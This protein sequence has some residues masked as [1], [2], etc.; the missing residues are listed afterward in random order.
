LPGIVAVFTAADI[1]RLV[2]PLIAVS[3]MKDYRPTPMHL[4]AS[5]KVR[6]VG[7][8]TVAVLAEHRYLA[9][10][11]LA[12]IDI[13][14]ERLPALTDPEHAI[15]PEAT[16]LH[17]D[18]GSNV[19]LAREFARGNVDAVFSSAAVK[20]GARFR[21]HRKTPL[22]LENRSYLAEYDPGRG[23]L[24]LTS[25]TQVPGIVRDALC[26]LLDLPGH[27]VRVVAQD[28]GGGFG[29]KASL[30]PEEVLVCVLARHLKRA[31][32]WTSDRLED[33]LTTT[34]AFDET[35]DAQLALDQDG[36]ILALSAE[37][38]QRC[39]RVLDLSLDCRSGAGPGDQL[40]AGALSH[41]HLSGPRARCRNLQSP[42]RT[43]PRSRPAN[44]HVRNGT[45]HG[46]GSA[47]SRYRPR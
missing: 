7:E 33:L 24:T 32:R 21:S 36:R 28:V 3:R 29:G 42:R 6:Y 40:P 22:A 13:Q 45:A 27:S 10:D 23:L 16:L 1:D 9:E 38:D 12:H 25:S 31:V 20:V 35:V 30:Y 18:I 43:L 19:L 34:Q 47:P 5:G 41:R 17:E 46:H 8:P 44:F 14:F 39:R 26:D 11:A 37:G 2:N 15:R 4:L